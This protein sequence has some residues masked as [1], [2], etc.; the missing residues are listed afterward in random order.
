MMIISPPGWFWMGEGEGRHKRALRQSYAIASKEVTVAQF[1]KFRPDHETVK[2]F[3][4]SE[5]C[6]ANNVCWYDAAAYCNWLS[7]QEGIDPGQWCYQPNGEGK[8]AAGMK[9]VPDAL[10]RK[11]YR[12]PTEAEWEYGCRAGSTTKFSFG[13]SEE[14][15]GWYAWNLFNANSTTHPVGALK[16]NDFGLFDMHG[17]AWEWCQ[18]ILQGGDEKNEDKIVEPL[19]DAVVVG[20]KK[21]RVLRGGYFNCGFRNI[22]SADYSWLPASQRLQYAGFRVAR[23][24]RAEK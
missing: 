2:A 14:L 1:R 24:L 5:D 21:P 7:E 17:N 8:Y 18:G 15:A 3:I 4:L 11:G 6:P 16:P 13:E 12:L 9:I 23:S 10:L 20:E 19:P 22:R